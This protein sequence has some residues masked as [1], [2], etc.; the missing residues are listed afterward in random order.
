MGVAFGIDDNPFMRECVAALEEMGVPR[1]VIVNNV[2]RI[3]CVA[4]AG[5]F[6][7][8]TVTFM[9]RKSSATPRP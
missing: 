4:Q 9:G 8:F 7:R 2:T 5:E 1:E 3:D 6:T